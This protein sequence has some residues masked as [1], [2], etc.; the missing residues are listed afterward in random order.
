MEKEKGEEGGTPE[1]CENRE[2]IDLSKH[3][4][5]DVHISVY[6]SVQSKYHSLLE[7]SFTSLKILPI[8]KHMA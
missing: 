4:K 6:Q 1:T 3:E 7:D 5:V 8:R 2:R